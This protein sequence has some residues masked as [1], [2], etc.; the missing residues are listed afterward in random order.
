MSLL[1]QHTWLQNIASSAVPLLLGAVG[2][3]V[4]SAVE[5]W[6]QSDRERRELLIRQCR[7]EWMTICASREAWILEGP[8]YQ[9]E[10]ISRLPDL[11]TSSHPNGLWLRNVEVRAVLEATSWS[12]PSKQ[13]YGFLEG[14]RTWIV[15]DCLPQEP[16]EQSIDANID[17]RPAIM[18]SKGLDEICDWIERV[19]SHYSVASSKLKRAIR[20]VLGD[21]LRMLAQQ[22]RRKVFGGRLTPQ[23]VSFLDDTMSW[24]EVYRTHAAST[25]KQR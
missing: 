9:E 18:S 4:V 10:S 17:P 21:T 11:P 6:I 2:G 25:T 5:T 13:Y 8:E 24:N 23:A 1:G 3:G 16:K 7:T 19:A 15:R 12:T 20:V 14:R 22:H